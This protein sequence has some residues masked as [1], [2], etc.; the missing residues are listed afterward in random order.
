MASWRCH[1]ASSAAQVSAQELAQF[2]TRNGRTIHSSPAPSCIIS[3]RPH[4]LARPGISSTTHP[5]RSL[6]RLSLASLILSNSF[7]RST[8]HPCPSLLLLSSNT[9]RSSLETTTPCPQFPNTASSDPSARCSAGGEGPR[10]V[11]IK[12]RRVPVSAIMSRIGACER[13]VVI[14]WAYVHS[15]GVLNMNSPPSCGMVLCAGSG[16]DLSSRFGKGRTQVFR[17]ASLL[18]ASRPSTSPLPRPSSRNP[19]S[20]PPPRRHVSVGSSPVHG[21]RPTSDP[22]TSRTGSEELSLSKG[23]R[24]RSN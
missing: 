4:T 5:H 1:I 8:F 24:D 7:S 19:P 16:S 13:V 10:S 21:R 11:C 14:L 12:S 6:L 23:V 22:C 18:H 2:P 17:A 15:W 20:H 9:S 3:C